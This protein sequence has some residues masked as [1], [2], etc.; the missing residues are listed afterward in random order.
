MKV[1][2]EEDECKSYWKRTNESHIRGGRLGEKGVPQAPGSTSYTKAEL[3]LSVP[4]RFLSCHSCSI[5]ARS[6]GMSGKGGRGVGQAHIIS[7]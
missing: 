2:L 7:H 5:R 4:G 3:D 1:I 6:F